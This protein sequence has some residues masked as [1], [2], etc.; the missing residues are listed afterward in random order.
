MHCFPLFSIMRR[1]LKDVVSLDMYDLAK[2]TKYELQEVLAPI[3]DATHK[4][5]E[6]IK[7]EKLESPALS[8]LTKSGGALSSK[9]KDKQALMHEI[10]RGQAFLSYAT[11]RIGTYSDKPGA[12]EYTKQRNRTSGDG[13]FFTNEVKPNGKNGKIRIPDYSDLSDRKKGRFW[14]VLHKIKQNGVQ[15]SPEMYNE[16]NM[17]IRTVVKSNDP[18]GAFMKIIPEEAKNYVLEKSEMEKDSDYHRGKIKKK[19]LDEYW[20]DKITSMYSAYIDWKMEHP[21]F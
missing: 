7:K 17:M 15:L 6:R 10:M 9:G 3:R 4:R 12:R 20:T 19:D 13:F 18:V 21:E 11:S 16:E 5:V 8:A 14:T 1:T 2:M